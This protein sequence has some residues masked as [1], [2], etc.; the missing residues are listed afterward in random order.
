MARRVAKSVNEY[1]NNCAA[2]AVSKDGY[3]GWGAAKTKD[4]AKENAMKSCKEKGKDCEV[5]VTD[6]TADK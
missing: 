1:W 4:E 6:C 2:F 5:I 3:F